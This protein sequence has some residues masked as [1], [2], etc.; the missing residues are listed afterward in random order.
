MIALRVFLHRLRGEK[1]FASLDELKTA[2]AADVER[3]RE[4]LR[5]ARPV[6]SESGGDWDCIARPSAGT[7]T[8]LGRPVDG[9]RCTFRSRRIS[10]R[11]SL[12]AIT[13]PR[14]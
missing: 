13:R 4:I 5:E 11:A 2:I 10:W 8:Y 7:I 3:C 12:Q 14:R 1:R 9:P 6:A